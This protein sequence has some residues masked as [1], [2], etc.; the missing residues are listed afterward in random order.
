[1][2]EREAFYSH[3]SLK[4]LNNMKVLQEDGYVY[5]ETVHGFKIYFYTKI[6]LFFFQFCFSK[7]SWKS[8][9]ITT[10]VF[11]L[12]SKKNILFYLEGREREISMFYLL[13]HSPGSHKSGWGQ[14]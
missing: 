2:G 4:L 13:V 1:M 5:Y 10:S 9:S 11:F 7:N 6:K 14:A 12:F 8:S 3:T